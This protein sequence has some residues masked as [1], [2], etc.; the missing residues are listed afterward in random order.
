MREE[1][2]LQF[3]AASKL[4]DE[5]SHLVIQYIS[6]HSEKKDKFIKNK[7]KEVIG[8][9]I[10]S[11]IDEYLEKY[12]GPQDSLGGHI[13]NITMHFC[14]NRPKPVKDI[15]KDELIE[16]IRRIID[17]HIEWHK[18]CVF[19]GGLGYWEYVEY[20]AELLR[21]NFAN[22]SDEYFTHQIAERDNLFDPTDVHFKYTVEEI[23]EKIWDGGRLK[24]EKTDSG[25]L[26]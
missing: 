12:Y 19:E 16:I 5:I 2:E 15:T 24:T 18:E 1:L 8:K 23:A 7:F 9:D 6:Y 26:S 21:I 13:R 14:W 20:Y 11:Y 17:S 22:Y 10:S 25:G 3:E 4:F